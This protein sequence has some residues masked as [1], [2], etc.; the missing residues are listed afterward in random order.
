MTFS[1][2]EWALIQ[3]HYGQGDITFEPV[4]KKVEVNDD[5]PPMV[6]YELNRQKGGEY[7]KKEDWG[8]ALHYFE[9]AA[10]DKENIWLRGRINK[11]K[12]KLDEDYS[13]R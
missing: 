3:K 6:N 9:E 5:K 13:N 4:G 2:P 11:C 8:K 12:E 1:E 10:K 7:Y